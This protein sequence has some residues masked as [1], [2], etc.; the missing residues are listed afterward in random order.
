MLVQVDHAFARSREFHE[1]VVLGFERRRDESQREEEE[2][3]DWSPQH[4]GCC[5]GNMGR[6]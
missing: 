4:L 2:S 1:F 3:E 5:C 6:V